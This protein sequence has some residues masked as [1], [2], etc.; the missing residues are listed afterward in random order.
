MDAMSARWI[1]AV[2]VALVALG[3][4]LRTGSAPPHD[5]ILAAIEAARAEGAT[6]AIVNGW[7]ISFASPPA[8]S[9]PDESWVD[10]Y[11]LTPV[12]PIAKLRNWLALLG[13]P[14][15]LVVVLLAVAA[16]RTKSTGA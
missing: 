9:N 16:R 4:L 11:I 2:V 15:A 6:K 12:S 13:V 14:I 3:F 10:A 8:A 5:E 1:A 7:E